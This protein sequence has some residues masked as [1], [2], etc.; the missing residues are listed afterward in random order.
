V[1]V[2]DRRAKESF[3]PPVNQNIPKY[4]HQTS[5]D[6][7]VV[8][9]NSRDIY[10]GKCGSA[11]SRT[12]YANLIQEWLASGRVMTSYSRKSWMTGN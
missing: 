11:Q 8:N 1:H 6:L 10:L 4:R 12:K 9:V 3:V 2:L 5:H 7:A